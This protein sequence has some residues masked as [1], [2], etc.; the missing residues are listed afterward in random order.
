[1]NPDEAPESVAPVEKVHRVRRRAGRRALVNSDN[2]PVTTH[3]YGWSAGRDGF[4]V[5]ARKG[6]RVGV[7][8]PT[9]VAD[10]WGEFSITGLAP[11]DCLADAQEGNDEDNHQNESGMARY[12]E[13]NA[14]VT[15]Q[16]GGP[17]IAALQAAP[18]DQ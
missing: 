4:I 16:A 18:T 2:L 15:I 10:R 12:G 11:G 6:A 17:T 7:T 13:K 9:G 14:K 8:P 1:M 3:L 5:L